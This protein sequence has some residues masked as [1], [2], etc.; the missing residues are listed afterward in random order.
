MINQ[1]EIASEQKD[2]NL[3][4]TLAHETRKNN[5]GRKLF[6]SL[7]VVVAIAGAAINTACGNGDNGDEDEPIATSVVTSINAEVAGVNPSV[8]LVRLGY[9]D[10]DNKTWSTL[11]QGTFSNGI[12]TINFS[13]I[14]V[15]A[16]LLRSIENTFETR[17]V[18]II[19]NTDARVALFEE[20]IGF[21][22]DNKRLGTFE[23]RSSSSKNGAKAN[24]VFSNS[25][26][27]ITVKGESTDVWEMSLKNGW[28]FIYWWCQDNPCTFTT[29]EPNDMKWFWEVEPEVTKENG[30]VVFSGTEATS[31]ALRA[32]VRNLLAIHDT[33]FLEPSGTWRGVELE[34]SRARTVALKTVFV[35]D[36]DKVWG[37]GILDPDEIS[38]A[39]SA[40]LASRLFEIKAGKVIAD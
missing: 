33:V 19:S 20:F 29:S 12:I 38:K 17:D 3:A 8:T 32:A 28:N 13:E 36:E 30:R 7:C 35:L 1:I 2:S 5:A 11:G 40:Y 18:L 22:A 39:D 23:Y 16:R 26:V 25:D 27:T 31:G 6:L 9:W 10:E 34:L 37:Y 14:S 21:D 15:P 4:S 24:L